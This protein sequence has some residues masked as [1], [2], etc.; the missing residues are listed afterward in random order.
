MYTVLA[1]LL[2][3]SL[4]SN[5][6]LHF[7][8]ISHRWSGARTPERRKRFKNVSSH[9]NRFVFAGDFMWRIKKYKVSQFSKKVFSSLHFPETKIESHDALKVTVLSRVYRFS[10]E[11]KFY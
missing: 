11:V 7:A 10:L 3:L 1:V 9:R 6:S 8:F 2:A 4:A 5:R